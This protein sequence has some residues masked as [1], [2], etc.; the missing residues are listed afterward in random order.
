VPPDPEARPERSVEW[1]LLVQQGQWA[2]LDLMVQLEQVVL[3]GRVVLS[4]QLVCRV[5]LGRLASLDS[6]DHKGLTAVQAYLVVLVPQ[7]HKVLLGRPVLRVPTVHP[8]LKVSLDL[9]ETQELLARQ[10]TLGRV[11]LEGL[12][13]CQV[14]LEHAV[15]PV[16]LG[17]KVQLVCSEELVLLVQLGSLV[18]A[19][20]WDFLGQSAK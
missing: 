6:L 19:V 1:V 4:V 17:L 18:A 15:R 2:V 3:P 9:E 8:V 10:A 7:G 12:M 13:E 20:W 11:E 5:L 14:L 16:R